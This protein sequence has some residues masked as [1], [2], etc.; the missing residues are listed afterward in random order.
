M[1]DYK[2]FEKK[3]VTQMENALKSWSKEN[4][5]IYIFALDLARGADSVGVIANT[6]H[7]L[8]YLNKQADKDSP[9]YYLFKYCEDEWELFDAFEDISKE[10]RKYIDENSDAFSDPKTYEYTEAFDEHCGKIT[11]SCRNALICFAKEYPKLLFTFNIRDYMDTDE[12]IEMF[13]KL[14]GAQA[15]KE[16]AEHIDEFA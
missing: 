15:A 8:H 6:E 14:N 3:L 10:M 9:D 4:D 11:D 5:D 16:Y 12:R 7:Y 13:E 2:E 1:F